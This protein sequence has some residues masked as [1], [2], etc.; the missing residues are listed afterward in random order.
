MLKYQQTA[1]E[2][3]AYIEQHALQQGD[4]L[5][6]LEQLIRQFQVS[7]TTMTKALELLER[8]GIIF[9]VRGS[10]IFVRKTNRKGYIKLFSTQGFKQNLV[11]HDIQ[12]KVLTFELIPCPDEIAQNVG[13][14]PGEMVYYIKRIRYIDGNIL[15]LEESYYRQAIVPYLNREIIEQSI[16]EYLETAL[17]LNIGFS[18]MYMHVGKLTASIAGHLKLETGDPGL[19]IETVFHLTNGRPFDYS[20]I[21]YHYEHSQFVVQANGLYL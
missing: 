5:P 18:D 11:D 9:Q 19:T 13:S 20:V 6:V 4:K 3:E 7:K 14:S 8:K 2:I 17:G 10:G 15:C 16:F 12:S 21:T 1:T